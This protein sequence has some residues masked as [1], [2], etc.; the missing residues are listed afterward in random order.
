MLAFY[1]SE[2]DRQHVI[3]VFFFFLNYLLNKTINYTKLL[4]F[5]IHFIWIPYSEER[6]SV[7]PVV[8]TSEMDIWT[9]VV[10]LICFEMVELCCPDWVMRQ[11]NYRHHIPV[12]INTS[13]ALHAITCTGKNNDYD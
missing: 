8:C 7:A 10:P 4:L 3:Q 5:D 12:N 6:L 2:L 1:Q 11:F 9:I 13:N